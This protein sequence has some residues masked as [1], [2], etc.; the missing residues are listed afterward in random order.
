MRRGR[1]LIAL[2]IAAVGLITWWS[3]REVNPITGETQHIALSPEQE[4]VLGLQS[5][6]QMAA[7]FGGLHPDESVQRD[8]QSVGQ[9][10]VESS[11][12]RQSPYQF[13]FAVLADAE[14][15]NAFALPGGPIFI[16]RALLERLE[17][18]AQLAGVLGHEIGHVIGRHSAEQIAKSQLAQSLITAVGVAASGDAGQGGAQA[19]QIA[20]VVAQMVQMKYGREDELQSDSLGVDI[21]SEAGFDP[22]AMQRVMQIL[23]EASGGARAPEFMSSHPD[24]GNRQALIQS[25]IERKFPQGVPANLSLGRTIQM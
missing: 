7:E 19:A 14:T 24:P 20:G 3:S 16:T 10:L 8:I 25:A 23:A 5:A 18:E 4:I 21:M 12:A 2:A 1:L 22:R 11:A 6:P 9:R 17:N 15:V 13:R